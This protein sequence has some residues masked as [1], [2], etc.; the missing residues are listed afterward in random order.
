VQYNKRYFFKDIFLCVLVVHCVALLMVFVYDTGKF[1]QERFVINTHNLQSTIVFMPLKKRI[2]QPKT[3]A[4]KEFKKDGVRKVLSYEEYEKKVASAVKTAQTSV[5]VE[6]NKQEQKVKVSVQK[7]S[8]TQAKT[9]SKKEKTPV[10]KQTTKKSATTIKQEDKKKII[11]EEKKLIKKQEA[12][13]VEV[14]IE[15][16]IEEKLQA[17]VIKK[18]EKIEQVQD[19]KQPI[20]EEKSVVEHIVP[21]LIPAQA[22]QLVVSSSQSEQDLKSDAI[23]NDDIDLENVS[24]VGSLDLEKMQINEQ[25]QAEIIKYYT[26]PIGTS[27]KAVCQL[28]IVVGKDGK[29]E[30]VTV[31][32]GSGSMANDICARAAL[33]KVLFPKEVVGKEIIIELGQS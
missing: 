32:K 23:D 2:E 6:K 1:H 25:I 11:A 3:V 31:K 29:A 20:Q 9:V 19:Q 30:R 18:E 28:S 17:S 15:K 4:S 5:K 22:D 26:P 8:L 27:K 10:V 12:K 33:L 24:F 16:K 7:K 21:T 14:K 13:K